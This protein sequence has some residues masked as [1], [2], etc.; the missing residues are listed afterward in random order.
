MSSN[1]LDYE[2]LEKMNQAA[3]KNV[4]NLKKVTDEVVVANDQL[5]NKFSEYQTRKSRCAVSHDD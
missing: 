3:S 5:N 2:L 4:E 1:L